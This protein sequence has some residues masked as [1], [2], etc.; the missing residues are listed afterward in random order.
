MERVIK[1]VTPIPQE[2]LQIYTMEQTVD[3]ENAKPIPQE[4]V[5]I[6]TMEQT[7]DVSF[8]QNFEKIGERVQLIPQD[9]LHHRILEQIVCHAPVRVATSTAGAGATC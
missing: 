1:G 7:V 3:I 6:Y 8:P 4:R 5:Q 2:R 9:Q